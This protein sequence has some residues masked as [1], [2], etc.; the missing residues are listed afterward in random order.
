MTDT[1]LLDRPQ[2]HWI[3]W[4]NTAEAVCH[5]GERMTGSTNPTMGR[6]LGMAIAK[7]FREVSQ[8]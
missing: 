2:S 8:P 3:V 1:E 5:C 4:S 6:S 7:H